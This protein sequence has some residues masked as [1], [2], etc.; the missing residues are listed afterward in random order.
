MKISELVATMALAILLPACGTVVSGTDQ[1]VTIRTEPAGA[2]VELADGRTCTSPCT[3]TADRNRLLTAT[4]RKEGCRSEIGQLVPRVPESGS[5]W[6]S[7]FDYQMGGAYSLEPNPLT[8]RL[9]CGK[10]ETMLGLT[11]E[12]EAVMTSFG[13]AYAGIK[14]EPLPAGGLLRRPGPDDGTGRRP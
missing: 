3:L 8:V 5:L 6:L 12:D 7:V 1:E 2:E 14:T 10:G 11:A 13:E 4:V 9:R